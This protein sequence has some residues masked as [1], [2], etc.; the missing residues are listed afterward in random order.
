M[1]VSACVLGSRGPRGIDGERQTKHSK[2]GKEWNSG[3]EKCLRLVKN[4][5]ITITLSS[6]VTLPNFAPILGDSVFFSGFHL[7][8]L[9]HAMAADLGGTPCASADLLQPYTL[10][11]ANEREKSIRKHYLVLRKI[12]PNRRW[13]APSPAH[14]AHNLIC[15]IPTSVGSMR[16]PAGI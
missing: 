7:T 1:C 14:K 5:L 6:Y 16:M 10:N 9:W 13:Q 12:W 3:G 4:K 15:R 8:C 11:M 2:W